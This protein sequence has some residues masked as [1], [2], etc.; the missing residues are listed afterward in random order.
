MPYQKKFDIIYVEFSRKCDVMVIKRSVVIFCLILA[1]IV[2]Y[3]IWRTNTGTFSVIRSADYVEPAPDDG[4]V[5][6]NKADEDELATLDGIGASTARKIIEYRNITP[7]NTIEELMN[8][9]GI[10]EKKY[11]AIKDNIK[12]K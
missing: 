11:E 2:G 4:R 3:D 8:V 9:S 12:V 10:G 7:F 1:T 5:N 6:I